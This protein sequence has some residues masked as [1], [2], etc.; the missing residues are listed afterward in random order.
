MREI[1]ALFPSLGRLVLLA[2]LCAATP[3]AFAAAPMEEQ[4]NP[5][6]RE[7]RATNAQLLEDF[8]HYVLIANYELA[9]ANAS[10]LISR[11][12]EPA[13]F[14]ALIEDSAT[15]QQRFD[16]AYRQAILV[17]ELEDHAA[18]LQELYEGARLSRARDPREIEANIALL[19]G[20]SRAQLLGR[21]RLISAG[22]YAVPQLVRV[23]QERQNQP[24]QTE[25]T[26]VLIALGR[27]ATIPLG[28][29]LLE[30]DAPTQET[31]S[32]ILGRIGYPQALP[33]LAQ[34]RDTTQ[35]DAVR[36][37][38]IAAIESI[39]PQPEMGESVAD[40]YRGLGE[41]YYDQSRSVT[42]FPGEEFQLFWTFEPALGLEPQAVRTEVFHET[43]AMD[44]ARRALVLDPSDR[45]AMELW[46][47]AN[48][49][50]ELETPEGYEN[51]LYGPG[52]RDA[53]YYAVASGPAA[54]QGVLGRALDD[55][56]TPLARRAIEALSRCA[57]AGGLT[58]DGVSSLV[59][60]LGYPDRRV[61]FEAALALGQAKP[62]AAFNGAERVVP[63]LAGTLRDAA[64]S[65]AV[66]LASTLERQQEL[67]EIAEGMGYQVLPPGASL[68]EVQTPISEVISVDLVLSELPTE[69]T[70][71]L[72]EEARR[73][74]RLQATPIFA[75]LS[76][77]GLIQHSTTF[78][79]DRMT[80]LGREGISD[81]RIAESAAE[82]VKRASGE[83][84][85]EEEATSYAMQSLDVLRDL[86]VGSG[87]SGSVGALS[88][89]DAAVPL[90]WALENTEGDLRLRVADVLSYIGVQS[91]Q[92]SLLDAAMKSDDEEERVNLLSRVNDA[93]RRF[94]N[95]VE[96]RQVRWL[97]ERADLAM[98]EEATVA[99]SLIGA[100]NLSNDKLVPLVVNGG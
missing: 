65:Y 20:T 25:V 78:E 27:Q 64:K 88:V 22:E 15:M 86:A 39:G 81:E 17:P 69:S 93:A 7:D 3:A 98:G 26:A 1:S 57:G 74:A 21:Q 73:T 99:A 63:I 10:A 79:S 54:L 83:P 100:L 18:K 5:Q 38:A 71:A 87:A 51:P 19:T 43:M 68:A 40:F 4:E 30:T 53:L 82:L 70:V 46:V 50:R 23:L 34:T 77:S 76:S 33:F 37:A 95:L 49:S 62:V 58:G 11:D 59:N 66:V 85:T 92:V 2:G 72:I 16:R 55:R 24:L 97:L 42:S 8:C 67:R 29:A 12:L 94:G 32:R 31:I 80:A 14:L 96:D 48:L 41:Q 84:I 28:V 90:T 60:A 6:A 47:A 13:A 45:S 61:R 75:L 36:A 9:S 89:N 91:V 44:M 56:N 52:R 35:S